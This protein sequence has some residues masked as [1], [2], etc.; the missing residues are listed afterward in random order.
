MPSPPPV[1]FTPDLRAAMAERLGGMSPVQGQASPGLKAAAVAIVV[2]PCDQGHAHF[3]LTVR[4]SRP[5]RHSGQFAL[6]GG[7]I[8]PGETPDA[9]ARRECLEEI[10]LHLPQDSLLGR[11]DD[12]ETRSGYVIAPHVYWSPGLAELNPDPH[13]VALVKHVP[14]SVLNAPGSPVLEPGD[15]PGRPILRLSVGEDNLHAPTAALLYQFREVAMHG[16][17]LSVAH[18]DQPDFARR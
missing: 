5:G 2:T 18:F 8:E 12:Y 15:T 11:L 7:V 13:E 14:L 16:R 4:A 3:L 17:Y 9:A 10:G 1:A 6:P